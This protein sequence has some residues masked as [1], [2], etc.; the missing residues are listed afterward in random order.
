MILSIY[1]MFSDDQAITGNAASSNVIDL[2]PI[3]NVPFTSTQ[4]ARDIAKGNPVPILIQVTVAFA[5][6]VTLT[7]TLQSDNDEAFGSA[8][9]VAATPAIGVASLVPGYRFPI[10]YVPP[11]LG[12]RYLR[13][14]YTVSTSATA[15]K[16]TAGIVAGHQDY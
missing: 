1:N 2:G 13:L 12:E 15:G 8:A 4:L 11:G 16:I 14:Y 9:T 7:V 6:I 10:L 3:G 5:T